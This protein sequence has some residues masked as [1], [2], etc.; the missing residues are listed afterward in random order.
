MEADFWLERWEAG[1]TGFHQTRISPSLQTHWG[2]LGLP[3]DSR[4]LVPLAGKSL[5][6]VWLAEQGHQVLAI[7]LSP[8]AVSQFFT[9]QGLT[10]GIEQTDSGT[11]YRS[12]PIE[13]LCA[14]IFA[15]P[16]RLLAGVAACYDRASLIALKPDQRR[17]YARHVYGA[18]P[19]GCRGLLLTLE[20]PQSEMNGPPFSV[21][22]QELESLLASSWKVQRLEREDILADEKKFIQRGVSSLHACTY[23]LDSE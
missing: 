22:E 11:L 9:E 3:Q 4:V 23:R 6:I 12:G 13:F 16:A 21:P 14:D 7:E 18:L 2:S 5:D 10:P 8:V 1:Q 17:Q 19:R 15:V 20:Y